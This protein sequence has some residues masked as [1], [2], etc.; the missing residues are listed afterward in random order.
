VQ[1]I[2]I[3]PNG[4]MA[5]VYFLYK[6]SV[7]GVTVIDGKKGH[8]DQISDPFPADGQQTDVVVPRMS[9]NTVTSGEIHLR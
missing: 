9:Y 6:E 1:S 2:A 3:S 5:T 7:L 4:K 8:P